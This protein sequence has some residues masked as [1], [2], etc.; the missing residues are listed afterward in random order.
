MADAKI[1]FLPPAYAQIKRKGAWLPI[2]VRS[3]EHLKG[4]KLRVTAKGE[5]RWD[6]PINSVRSDDARLA[7]LILQARKRGIGDKVTG[8]LRSIAD[9]TDALV[10]G[11]DPK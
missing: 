6:C 7:A 2:S 11:E 8:I 10:R 3:V 9:M 1:D 4:G 5:G